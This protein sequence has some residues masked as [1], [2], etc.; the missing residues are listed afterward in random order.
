M[1]WW[2]ITELHEKKRILRVK[3]LLKCFY[4]TG[5]LRTAKISNVWGD[6]L[7]RWLWVFFRETFIFF[8]LHSCKIN[9]QTPLYGGHFNLVDNS[10]L[11]CYTL[12]PT[13][14]HSFFRNLPPFS[15]LR[16][17]CHLTSYVEGFAKQSKIITNGRLNRICLT[18][19]SLSFKRTDKSCTEQPKSYNPPPPL[20]LPVVISTIQRL[21]LFLFC[22]FLFIFRSALRERCILGK[23]TK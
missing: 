22:F 21:K 8:S 9:A 11:P 18:Q 4:V 12:P 14:H 19:A 15:Y 3:P 7:R 16:R 13:Q 5:A 20:R 17:C 10:K 1:L 23:F 6:N 2:C